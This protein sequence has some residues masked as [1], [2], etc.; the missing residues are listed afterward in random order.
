M[1]TA[2]G[3]LAVST[4]TICSRTRSAAS[5]RT[6]LGRQ[7]ERSSPT[8]P[9]LP[10][11]CCPSSGSCGTSRTSKT[12]SVSSALCISRRS[13]RLP[14]Q[15]AGFKDDIDENKEESRFSMEASYQYLLHLSKLFHA[16]DCRGIDQQS[17]ALMVNEFLGYFLGVIGNEVSNLHTNC[18]QLASTTRIWACLRHLIQMQS[19]QSQKERPLHTCMVA[20]LRPIPWSK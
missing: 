16:I 18:S 9:R 1:M 6:G 7:T 20:R 14:R 13:R 3:C 19:L 15:R 8:C 10:P 4:S 5:K 12:P 17:R 2:R 11:H